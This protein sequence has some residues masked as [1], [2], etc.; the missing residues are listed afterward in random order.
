MGAVVA[1]EG[2][3]TAEENYNYYS[4]SAHPIVGPTPSDFKLNV[5]FYEGTD[6]LT[7]NFFANLDGGGSKGTKLDVDISIEGHDGND[8]VIL[9]DDVTKKGSE[10]LET[11]NHEYQGRFTYDRNTDGGVIG[12]FS[13]ED[14]FVIS[15]QFLNSGSVKTGSFLLKQWV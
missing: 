10:L 1:Y 6:G 2:D 11:E 3:K 5:F 14:A 7:L 15:M 4:A 12:P 9:S 8:G 13:K